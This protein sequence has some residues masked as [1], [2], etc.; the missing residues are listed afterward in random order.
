MTNHAA[1]AA[2]GANKD[3]GTK[4]AGTEI[5]TPHR[6]PSFRPRTTPR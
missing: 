6:P 1:S 3:V 4:P 5:V 2:I